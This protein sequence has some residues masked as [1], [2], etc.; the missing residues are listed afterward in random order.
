ML[1]VH[2]CSQ[3]FWNVF[4]PVEG[5]SVLSFG[6]E[7]GWLPGAWSSQLEFW[8]FFPTLVRI[9]APTLDHRGDKH[10]KLL[11]DGVWMETAPI[12]IPVRTSPRLPVSQLPQ[13]PCCAPSRLRALCSQAH[14]QRIP[15]PR[16]SPSICCARDG[17]IPLSPNL[18]GPYRPHLKPK[19]TPLSLSLDFLPGSFPS[20]RG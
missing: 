2:P 1:G 4:I 3:P 8:N 11:L 10:L 5:F 20:L 13:F 15:S 19:V 18:S 12:S 14:V 17:S 7:Q 6:R 16:A 9:G